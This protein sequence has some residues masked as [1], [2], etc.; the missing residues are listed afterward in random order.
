MQSTISKNSLIDTCFFFPSISFAMFKQSLYA[1]LSSSLLIPVAI[2][3][4]PSWVYPGRIMKLWMTSAFLRLF[5][6][7]ISFTVECPPPSVF[8]QNDEIL[9]TDYSIGD[10]SHPLSKVYVPILVF[11]DLVEHRNDG[12]FIEL[13]PEFA[14]S[15]HKALES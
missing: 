2:Y 7:M 8:L 4:S 15:L 3:A 9:G 12:L 14:H 13:K 5:L 10:G 1:K 11:I 6:L